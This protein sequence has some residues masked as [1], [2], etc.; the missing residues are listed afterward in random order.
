[1]TLLG[2][3]CCAHAE[4]W[5]GCVVHE[6]GSARLKEAAH[7]KSPP[8]S[9]SGQPHPSPARTQPKHQA[10][11][12]PEQLPIM[13]LT[14]LE[15]ENFKSYKGRQTIGSVRRTSI[16]VPFAPVAERSTLR[17]GLPWP[18]PL[19]YICSRGMQGYC[20]T[21]LPTACVCARACVCLELNLRRSCVVLQAVLAIH[22]SYRAKWSRYRMR[23]AARA[24]LSGVSGPAGML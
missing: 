20:T 12:T 3:C 14:R 7:S 23:V 6:D 18:M 8:L 19:P 2:G 21:M 11:S 10:Q 9:D 13:G 22:R 17:L 5:R 24:F 16:L 1:M 15:L 4:T